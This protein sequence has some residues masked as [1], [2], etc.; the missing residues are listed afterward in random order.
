MEICKRSELLIT[1]H[2]AVGAC[3]ESKW[4]ETA[5]AKFPEQLHSAQGS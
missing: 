4:V 3:R 2:S 5:G 1:G